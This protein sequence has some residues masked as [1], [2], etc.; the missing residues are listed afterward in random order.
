MDQVKLRLR[1]MQFARL[2]DQIYPEYL[3]LGK[4]IS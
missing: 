1:D 3:N 4:I 2:I